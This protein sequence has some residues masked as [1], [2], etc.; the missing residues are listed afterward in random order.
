MFVCHHCDTPA[1]V[2]PDHLFTGTNADNLRDMA[3][4]RRGRNQNSSTAHCSRGHEFTPENTW[5]DTRRTGNRHC[6]ECGRIR[7][8][9]NPEKRRESYR[10][11]AQKI[12]DRKRQALR[13]EAVRSAPV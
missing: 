3:T 11:A 8:S 1:C 12:R 5:F 10:K 7:A 9:A 4:K 6:R 13:H 2:R